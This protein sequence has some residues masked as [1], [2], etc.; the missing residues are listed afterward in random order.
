M[1][2]LVKGARV[3]DPASGRDGTGDVAVVDG[4]IV[5]SMPGKPDR[6]LDAKGLV[7]APGLIDLDS[8]FREPGYEYNATL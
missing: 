4:R 8:L 5:E 3:V 2:L 7:V 6:V 1:K